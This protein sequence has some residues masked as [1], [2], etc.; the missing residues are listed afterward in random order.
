MSETKAKPV[1]IRLAKY[2]AG[3]G[4]SSRRAAEELIANG[5]VSVNG[6]VVR[7]PAT[8]VFEGDKVTFDG[9]EI[10]LRRRNEPTVIIFHKPVGVVTTMKP[11]KE[12]GPCV[13]DLVQTGERVFPVGR[14][15][16]DSSGLL[17]LTDEGKLSLALTH[18]KHAV[19][20][21]YVVRLNRPLNPRDIARIQQGVIID[22]RPVR[23][24]TLE[25]TAGGRLRVIITEGRNRI[26][27][28]LFGHLNYIVLELKRVRVGSAVLGKLAV[29]KWRKLKPEEIE[30]L[31][32]ITGT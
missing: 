3:A 18:P 26:V 21:E 7:D 6:V 25:L 13:A 12:E 19:E 1:G 11:G 29:G 14:L 2:L 16:R 8:A 10:I 24:L 20:K 9:T 30:N 17:L 23:V 32:M 22:D 31:R 27:R 4:V 28:R 5:R 15:D